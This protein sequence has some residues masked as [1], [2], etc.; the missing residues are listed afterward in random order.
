MTQLNSPYAATPMLTAF[1]RSKGIETV[2]ADLSL[3]LALRLFSKK[4]IRAIAREIDRP[5]TPS[6]RFFRAQAGVYEE[7]IE[8]VVR[9][10]QGRDAS[11]AYLLARR[12]FLPEGPRFEVLD[13]SD[14]D[15]Q[16]E[17]QDRAKYYA[18]LY[19]DDIADAI[20]DA[21]DPRFELSRY[22][23]KLA[24]SAPSFT[25]IRK[26][27]EQSSTLIDRMIDQMTRELGRR[28]RPAVVGLTAPFP[29]NVYG[30]FR[31]AR[32]IKRSFPRVR[33]VLGG[34][35]VNTELRD[36]SDPTVFDYVDYITLDD[37]E[38]AFL[39][40]IDSI[41]RKNRRILRRVFVRERGKVIFSTGGSSS[42]LA[43]RRLPAP[44]F[45][46]LDLSKYISVCEMP[47][48][49][50]RLWSDGCWNKLM[51]AH[52]CYWRKCAFCDT[53]LDY[54]RRYDPSPASA[55]VDRIESVIRETGRHGF[56][57]VDEAV[58]PTLLR[59]LSIELLRRKVAIAWWCNIRFEKA[60]TP[61]L[62]G[63]MA[64][65]GCVAVTGGLEAAVD[66]LLALVNKGITVA[67][68]AHATRAFS[69][70]GILTH[71]YLMYGVPSQTAQETVD[72]LETVRRFFAAG[73]IQS[74]YWHRFAL[75]VHSPMA[76]D[77]ERYGICLSPVSRATF[78]RNEIPW[79]EKG[80]IDHGRFAFGLR[81]AV[82]NF[83][84]GV[85]LDRDVRDWFDFDVPR[86]SKFP[87]EWGRI[88]AGQSV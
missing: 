30:A 33:V 22:G 63:L 55:L 76:R 10:L 5:R 83:M 65:A 19:I 47:N 78:A 8:P 29:G 51:L 53:C 18:S 38:L 59:S 14:L 58:S 7:T 12:G 4:G 17:P 57:F 21:V 88:L 74:A 67:Q 1:L 40:V 72:A 77:P 50:H 6:V 52:G 3:G 60:F 39:S 79:T 23:E 56:H 61:E 34:G 85:G 41:K 37:G 54:I 80:G 42:G 31:I 81:K 15:R 62:A 20:H 84:H 49:M 27:L 2:Q 35:Y 32:A 36:L 48:P 26:S 69:D 87:R 16:M 86:P 9:F 28:H 70:T 11:L 68:A 43:H 25:P 24:A 82:Y 13:H 46:G 45:D 73:C 44:S 64:R 66:R 75:T 71:A